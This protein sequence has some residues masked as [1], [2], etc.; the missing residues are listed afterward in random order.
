MKRL[1]VIILIV[2]VVLGLVIGG[3]ILRNRGGEAELS[4]G[5][6]PGGQLP[7]TLPGLGGLAPQSGGTGLLPSEV[8]ILSSEPIESYFVY[9]KGVW[10]AV[11]SNGEIVEVQN[12]QLN[13]LSSTKIDDLI[14]ASFSF[15][16]KRVL[17][18]FGNRENP[19]TSIFDIKTKSW[20]PLEAGARRAAWSPND[21]RVVYFVPKGG[22]AALVTIDTGKFR[23]APK[24][25]IRM[26]VLGLVPNW[27]SKNQ[28]ILTEPPSSAILSSL[29]SFDLNSKTLTKLA[30]ESPG[31]EAVW[32]EEGGEGL[33]FS[34]AGGRG[35]SLKL[36][37]NTGKILE[38]LG[39][40]TL[41][42]KCVFSEGTISGENS[43][44]EAT[45]E[46]FLNCAVPRDAQAFA[47]S[48]LPDD[49][50]K[51]KLT[52]AD[53]FFQINLEDGSVTTISADPNRS[54]DAE[55]VRVLDDQLFFINRPDQKLYVISF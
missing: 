19:Q 11:R 24:E 51:K 34:A 39:F 32:D 44:T 50:Q 18:V 22:R 35:G 49:Y 10:A 8:T 37:D 38:S 5:R 14:G 54:F 52:T 47:G 13:A 16:G 36:I 28:V 4:D 33:L 17:A 7:G 40:L 48:A 43:S 41:A 25:L 27:I 3:L 55:R 45:S 20:E 2:V 21:N 12:G 9:S 42:S 53:D 29:W 23:A 30:T 1:I 46:K 31:L 26:N 15:D 6:T